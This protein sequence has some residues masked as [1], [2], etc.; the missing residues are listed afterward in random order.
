[1]WQDGARYSSILVHY[2]CVPA[3]GLL[4]PDEGLLKRPLV[5]RLHALN[6]REHRRV[7]YI[8]GVGRRIG[9]PLVREEDYA[10]LG[11]RSANTRV[12]TGWSR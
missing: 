9:C 11:E 12:E 10:L 7:L 5:C 6:G 1:M 4:D 8:V 3:C 2:V